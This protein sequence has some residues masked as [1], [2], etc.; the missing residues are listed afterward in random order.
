MGATKVNISDIGVGN[1]KLD[2]SCVT[3]YTVDDL[4][5]IMKNNNITPLLVCK[6]DKHIILHVQALVPIEVFNLPN[7][8]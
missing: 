5:N 7:Q 1:I 2:G 8:V 3:M 4:V 6:H